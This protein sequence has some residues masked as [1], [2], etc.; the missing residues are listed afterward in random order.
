MTRFEIQ[1]LASQNQDGVT[2]RA[3][4][5]ST[6]TIVSLRRFFPFGQDEEGGEGLDPQEG[7]A[8][9]SACQKLSRVDHPALR[10]TIYGDTDPVDG[11][12]FLVTEWIE[13]ESLAD[14]LGNNT[15]DPSMIIGLLRQALDV[16]M[17]LSKTLGNEA[18]WI[19]TKLEGIIVSNATESPSFSFRICPFKW[20]GTQAHAKDLTGMISLVEA[21]MGWKT[22]LVSD[23]AGLGLGGW[24]KLLRQ[25]PQM[26]LTQALDTLP[27]PNSD[28]V[29][30]TTSGISTIPVQQSYILA[31][32]NPTV[33]T[34][35]SI[36][37]MALS[38]CFTGA[39]IFFL[40]LHNVRKTESSTATIPEDGAIVEQQPEI[41]ETTPTAGTANPR[42]ETVTPSTETTIPSTVTTPLKTASWSPLAIST[43]AW[44]DASNTATIIST[45]GFVSQWNDIS[46]NNGHATQSANDFQPKTE[47][48]TIND[49]NAID[50]D[51]DKLNRAEINMNGKAIFAIVSTDEGDGGQIFSHSNVNNQLRM[52]GRGQIEYAANPARYENFRPSTNKLTIKKPGMVGFIFNTTLQYSVDGVFDDTAISETSSVG[53]AYNQFGARSE[54]SELLD[55]LVG[56]II[57]T[58]SIPDNDTRQKI[59]GYLAHKWRITENLPADHPY[60][61]SAPGPKGSEVKP[62][63]NS[64]TTAKI[65]NQ[66]ETV[67]PKTGSWSPAEISPAAWYDAADAT[68]FILSSGAV[69]QWNDKS[70]NA[71]NISQAT[72]TQRPTFA[73]K[74]VSFDGIDDL[75]FN[76][77]AFMYVNNRVD[78]YVVGAFDST[79]AD[80]RLLGESSSSN[81]NQLY[82]PFQSMGASVTDLSTMGAY[83][84]DDAN[85]IRFQHD[86]KSLSATGA[87]DLSTRK[88]YQVRDTGNSLT[89]RVNGGIATTVNYDRG[90]TTLTNFGIGGIPP[91]P[92]STT[93]SAWMRADVNE[94]IIVPSL[95]SD[96]DRQK[97]EGYL[98]HKWSLTGNLP[99]DHPYKL[100]SPGRS[101]SK[102]DTVK[103]SPV[104]ISIPKQQKPLTPKAALW[105]PTEIAPTAWYDAADT[106]T[107]AASNGRVSQWNDKSGGA[108]HLK[109]AKAS[110]QPTYKNSSIVME[111][112]DRLESDATTMSAF[113]GPTLNKCAA[114]AVIK[115]VSGDVLMQIESDITNRFNLEG[116][117]RFDFP[118]DTAGKLMGWSKPISNTGFTILAATANGTTQAA[119]VNGTLVGSKANSLS[120]TEA[121]GTR[122]VV[123]ARD[124]KRGGESSAIEVQELIFFDAVSDQDRQKTEGYLA[125]KWKLTGNLP[126]NHPYKSSAPTATPTVLEILTS[127]N[128][129]Y[130]KTLKEGDPVSLYGIVRSAKL[131]ST[132]KS[133]YLSFSEPVVETEIRVVIHGSEY[134]GGPFTEEGFTPLIG[135]TLVFNGTV[136]TEPFNDRPPFVKITEK[137]QIRLATSEDKQKS[138]A[139]L[140]S[141]V[142]TDSKP[143]AA[144]DIP[145][146]S[147]DDFEAIAKLELKKPAAVKG[148]IKS[149]NIP[150]PGSGL[151]IAFS[152]P[153]DGKQI[154]VVAYPKWFEGKIHNDNEFKSIENDLQRLVGKTVLFEGTYV[155]QVGN[156]TRRFVYITS[157][158]QI[159]ET[160]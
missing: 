122:F 24:I 142:S 22:K 77:D 3:L 87:L 104:A 149:V 100:S 138:T 4:D 21:L 44:Y 35:K 155:T 92:D 37:I 102:T 99:A 16:C 9:S 127:Q 125:H 61:L 130:I 157:R 30:E 148:I 5:K 143:E 1:D 48:R 135:K 29:T 63:N 46:G 13:G 134:E 10:K 151:Y 50:F 42:T 43:A 72:T 6:N 33:F 112:D 124:K 154:Q 85:I 117:S 144:S 131:S 90:N 14:V 34:K 118:N 160:K 18:V 58:E 96:S 11:M 75:L 146:F 89:G 82:L 47:M 153:W 156:N 15:M 86:T 76:T 120:V 56:E 126:P 55:G 60:K 147:P 39:F 65:S 110:N 20:L 114:I 12:P 159:K 115:Y 28:S 67:E 78:I 145:V 103:N 51:A 132:E 129:D 7:K 49:L 158:D 121:K 52:N 128:T 23:Q 27:S 95:L 111:M 73:S 68:T 64:P 116:N 91:R 105:S 81:S 93:G 74:T 139:A 69:S 54:N 150:K 66:S 19:D 108:K 32:A 94:I 152:D 62:I 38:A 71:R 53:A 8:F 106:S 41:L 113:V 141:A 26:S 101:A 80:R 84:R 107:I 97:I 136:Y 137:T 109:M 140:K 2:F 119:H 31:S 133:I 36:T 88:F 98:A 83:I 57:I 70:G 17:T 45:N 79:T 123:G 25:N 59:E 40:Y